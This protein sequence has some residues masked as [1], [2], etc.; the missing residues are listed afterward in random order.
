MITPPGGGAG[1]TN[2]KDP[3]GGDEP[4]GTP[5]DPEGEI[6]QHLLGSRE[7]DGMPRQSWYEQQPSLPHFLKK[8]IGR[9]YLS[10]GSRPI[11]LADVVILPFTQELQPMGLASSKF[12]EAAAEEYHEWKWRQ[13]RMKLGAVV[14]AKGHG[15]PQVFLLAIMSGDGKRVE[16]GLL[17]GVCRADL[18]MAS[19]KGQTVALCSLG[20][21]T[22]STGVAIA[23]DFREWLED[24]D[25]EKK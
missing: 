16:S 5:D 22:R 6:V 1:P 23:Q 21:P 8:L 10:C 2:P 12:Q 7:F 17:G 14:E 20:S 15:L 13:G 24:A 19:R 11:R 3:D 18:Q 25:R 9:I 4:P